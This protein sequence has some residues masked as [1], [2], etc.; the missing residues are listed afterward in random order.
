MGYYRIVGLV[1]A[2]ALE[3]AL[4]RVFNPVQALQLESYGRGLHWRLVPGSYGHWAIA[5]ARLLIARCNI[6]ATYEPEAH[7]SWR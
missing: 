7:M 3:T 6:Q 5:Q 2:L 4:L 1:D